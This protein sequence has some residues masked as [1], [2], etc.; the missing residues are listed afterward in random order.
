MKTIY[1]C[2]NLIHQINFFSVKEILVTIAVSGGLS[3]TVQA[4][5]RLT[6][7]MISESKVDSATIHFYNDGAFA[8]GDPADELKTLSEGFN[9]YTVS[10]DGEILASNGLPRFDCD[11]NIGLV[12]FNVEEGH[13]RMEVLKHFGFPEEI[14]VQL[15]DNFVNKMIDIIDVPLYPFDVTADLGSYSPTRFEVK[16]QATPASEDFKLR[17]TERCH[18]LDGQIEIAD[19][20]EGVIYTIMQYN[21]TVASFVGTGDTIKYQVPAATVKDGVNIFQVKSG[22]SYCQTDFYKNIAVV[23]YQ[24]FSA[25]PVSGQRCDEGSVAL[26]ATTISEGTVFKWY[27]SLDAEMPVKT[28][29]DPVFVTPALDKTTTYYVSATTVFGCEGPRK[30]VVAEITLPYAAAITASGD[31]LR[32]NYAQGNQWYLNGIMIPGAT[33]EKHVATQRGLYTLTVNNGSCS[34]SADFAFGDL[35]SMI[36]TAHP[37]PVVT[38]VTI[39]I[40]G[41]GR[42]AGTVRVV[43][44]LGRQVATVMLHAEGNAMVGQVDMTGLPVGIYVVRPAGINAAELKLIRL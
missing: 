39:Q 9:L 1:N 44:T 41:E 18:G 15:I 27:E 34:A 32:S 36:I 38:T 42:N 7:K 3:F 31:T 29:S 35:P 4:Q 10:A 6:I 13:Y 28:Q 2:L 23:V 8:F 40:S 26:K 14:K 37:N 16:L 20:Q 24:E 11:E 19:T 25:T 22:F 30:P 17:G 5:T 12:M 21:A 43:N 33:F